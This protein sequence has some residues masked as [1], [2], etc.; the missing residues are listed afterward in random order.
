META[1]TAR[2]GGVHMGEPV[3]AGQPGAGGGTVAATEEAEI[4][5]KVGEA[6]KFD[7][8]PGPGDEGSAGRGQ[9]FVLPEV[10]QLKR[11]GGLQVGGDG[12]QTANAEEAPDHES[13]SERIVV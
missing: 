10:S 13:W 6:G 2:S 5:E 7:R 4:G 12:Q 11:D 9:G 1:D 3:V 8:F